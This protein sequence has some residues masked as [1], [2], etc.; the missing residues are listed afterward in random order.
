MVEY[1]A[2]AIEDHRRELAQMP[3]RHREFVRAGNGA[4]LIAVALGLFTGGETSSGLQLLAGLVI[5]WGLWSFCIGVKRSRGQRDALAAG[6][7]LPSIAG[8]L[9][10]LIFLPFGLLNLAWLYCLVGGLTMFVLA[11]LRGMRTPGLPD[12]RQVP[13]LPISGPASREEAQRALRGKSGDA[14]Q[15]PKFRD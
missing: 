11:A 10:G 1:F 4:G 12:P 6:L 3:P 14:W 8:G 5:A 9:A 7:A 2:K 13:G 15:P